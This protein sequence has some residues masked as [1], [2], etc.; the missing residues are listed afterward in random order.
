[1]YSIKDLADLLNLSTDQVR[2]R[3]DVLGPTLDQF[4]KRGA[5][6]KILID[7]S[8]LELLRKVLDLEDEG[9]SFKEIQSRL[10]QELSDNGQEPKTTLDQAELI[11]EK[12]RS[13]NRLEEQIEELRQDKRFL[14]DRVTE[15]ETKLLAGDT[16]DKKGIIRRII[17]QIW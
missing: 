3:L 17:E 12:D 8:G 11:K 15:L 5:K 14:Q 6:N 7:N 1:M 4:T 9:L 2:N 16:V 10:N 13:I